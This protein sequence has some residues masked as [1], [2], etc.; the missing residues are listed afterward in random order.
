M[1]AGLEVGAVVGVGLIDYMLH[2]QARGGT[3]RAGD[4]QWALRYDWPLLRAKLTGD[5]LALDANRIGTNY[6]SHPFAGTL[7]YQVARSNHLSPTESFLFS[8]LGST[9]WEMFG[10]IR[11]TTSLNDLIVTPTAGFAIGEP[12][13][14]LSGFFARGKKSFSNE[15]L[16]FLFSPIGA[17]N[18]WTDGATPMRTA[19]PDALGFPTEPWH[20]FYASAGVAATSQSANG[21]SYPRATYGDLRVGLDMEIAVLPGYAGA[22]HESHVFDDGNVSSLR[23]GASFSGGKVRD[24]ILA[25]RAVPIGFYF[26]DADLGADER[27]RGHGALFGWRVAFEYGVHDWDRDR[28]RP[29]DHLAIVSPVGVAAEYTYSRGP[30]RV[31]TNFDLGGSIAG[32]TPYALSDYRVGR[33]T[34]GLPTSVKGDGYYHGLGITAAPSVEI[35]LG[36]LSFGARMRVDAFRPIEGFDE[37]E[38]TIDPNTKIFDRRTV[39]GAAIAW[40]PSKAPL[41][42]SIDGER[43]AR[44]GDIGRVHSDRSEMSVGLSVGVLF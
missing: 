39:V 40:A 37:A 44:M 14:Q 7:Y 33:E 4:K 21:P 36:D 12:L 27:P 20:R 5:S 11:E 2:T 17:I 31:K 10:E 16:S 8:V 28:A 35:G 23:F 38:G 15:L 19:A 9:I 3:T 26:R 42:I 43:R 6:V 13:M 41:R 22:G 34:T 1:R 25:T 32:V 24:G 30:F 29:L 18:R